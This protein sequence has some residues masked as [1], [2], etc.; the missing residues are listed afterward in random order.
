MAVG[1]D[2]TKVLDVVAD[3]GIRL[4]ALRRSFPGWSDARFEDA[5]AWLMREWIVSLHDGRVR[6]TTLA[7]P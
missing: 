2:A 1:R 6:R 3:T 7:A 5:V 4:D